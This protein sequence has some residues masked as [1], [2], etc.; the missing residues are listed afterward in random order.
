MTY[1]AGGKSYDI[2][3]TVIVA[4]CNG[5]FFGGGV[6]ISPVSKMDDGT[7]ELF[8]TN[9]VSKPGL[10]GL[11]SKVYTG[12]H[13]GHPKVKFQRS[14]KFEIKLEVPQL[15][16]TDGEVCGVVTE[17]SFEILPKALKV[18]H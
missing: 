12:S 16:E 3:K 18:L 6:K 10:L 1:I 5:M 2:K 14:E 17:V 4:V 7:L 8:A 13:V 15:L 11:V 9:H